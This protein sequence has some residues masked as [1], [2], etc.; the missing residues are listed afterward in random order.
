VQ[1]TIDT[2]RVVASGATFLAGFADTSVTTS[3]AWEFLVQ[4]RFAQSPPGLGARVLDASFA[5]VGEVAAVRNV[6]TGEIEMAV[7]W[8]A[9]GLA[10]PPSAPLRLTVTSFLSVN[11]QDDTVEIGG[12]S[13]SNALDALGD[14]GDPRQAVFPNAWDC[15]LSDGVVDWFVDVSF[16]ADGEVYAPVLITRYLANASSGNSEWVALRNVSPLTQSL[17]GLK[18]GDEEQPDPTTNVERLA[19]L[20]GSP[21]LSAGETF[22]VASDASQY[23]ARYGVN[24]AAEF[25]NASPTVPDLAT[26]APWFDMPAAG[27]FALANVGDH[28]LLLD[29]SNT[30][31]DVVNY[32]TG[33]FTGVIASAA[34]APDQLFARMP[35]GRD[36]DDNSAD[37]RVAAEDL[38]FA[39]GF[40][41]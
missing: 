40:E 18:L 7:P 33:T 19:A 37:F 6:S 8:S 10:G 12:P 25:V 21:L 38:L 28:V 24:P 15:D 23:L 17:A 34:P 29:A 4:T 16:A 14:C 20:P 31:L 26:F 36:T 5:E 22:V 32:G 27:S 41:E 11:T 9:L 1:I 13:V 30:V 3:A 39:D 2:D 35:A